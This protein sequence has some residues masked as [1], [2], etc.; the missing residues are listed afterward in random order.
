[1]KSTVS[2]AAFVLPLYHI[3]HIIK[4]LARC[5]LSRAFGTDGVANWVAEPVQFHIV[6]DLDKVFSCQDFCTWIFCDTEG[7][8]LATLSFKLLKSILPRNYGTILWDEACVTP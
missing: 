7:S 1:V 5:G 4:C 8:Q 3:T 6:N 2:S